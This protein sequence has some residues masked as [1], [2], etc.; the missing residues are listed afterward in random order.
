MPTASTSPAANAFHLTGGRRVEGNLLPE[1]EVWFDTYATPDLRVRDVISADLQYTILDFR[2]RYQQL[3][4][5]RKSTFPLS[6]TTS[7]SP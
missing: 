7:T 5:Q 3:N 2:N 1:F 6:A 4:R